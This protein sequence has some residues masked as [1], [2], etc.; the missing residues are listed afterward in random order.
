MGRQET[1]NAEGGDYENERYGA[2]HMRSYLETRCQTLA[3]IIERFHGNKKDLHI[4]EVGCGTGLTLE[5]LAQRDSST[6]L[7]GTDFSKTMLR[8]SHDKALK[9]KNR[10]SV[11]LGNAFGLPFNDH[12]FDVVFATR[13]IHQFYHKDKKTIHQELS[14]VT[15]KGGIVVLEFYA[16][17]YHWLRFHTGGRKGKSW[18]SY[19]SHYPRAKE[20]RDI[21][22]GTFEPIPVRLAGERVLHKFLGENGVQWLMKKAAH[23]PASALIDEYFVATRI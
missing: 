19:F 8:Q 20:I 16:Y 17:G 7:F 15:K 22:G 10:I 2:S 4:L 1:Y 23:S 9:T 5:F 11:T 18:E 21:V 14:R 13:F 6:K 3:D 12:Q